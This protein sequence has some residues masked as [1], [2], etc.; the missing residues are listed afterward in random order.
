MAGTTSETEPMT[1]ETRRDVRQKSRCLGKKCCVVSL[2]CLFLFLTFIALPGGVMLIVHGGKARRKGTLAGGIV[3]VCL[4]VLATICLLA[5]FFGRRRMQK[6]RAQ[7][8]V[9]T[10]D[11]V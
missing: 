8:T 7:N 11:P 1:G 2:V 5:A 9:T 10:T 4:P 3:L 6:L